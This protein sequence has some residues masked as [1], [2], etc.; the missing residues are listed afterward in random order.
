MKHVYYDRAS[1]AMLDAHPHT[2]LE[3]TWRIA[4]INVPSVSRGQGL[5]SGLLREFLADVDAEGLTVVLEP[6]PSGGLD[7]VELVAWYRRYGFEWYGD[8]W[9]SVMIR[10]PGGVSKTPAVDAGATS[11]GG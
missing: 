6:L 5:G 2:V 1:R 9:E 7:E 10:Y 4:R 8:S 3:G 11:A